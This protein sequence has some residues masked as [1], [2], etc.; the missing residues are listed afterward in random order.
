[1]MGSRS[2]SRASGM[3]MGTDTFQIS[4]ASPPRR[5]LFKISGEMLA[6]SDG[7]GI[8]S[9][10]LRDLAED[11]RGA[12]A[13]KCEMAL[14][15]GAGNIVRGAQLATEGVNRATADYMGMLGTVINALALADILRL[16][17]VPARVMTA[18]RMAPAAEPYERAAA[19]DSIERG[20]VVIFAAGTGNPYF[21]TDTAAALRAVEIGADLLAKGTK[22]DG[23]Y[24]KDPALHADALL[25]RRV[26][27]DQ[28]LKDRLGVMD[29]AAVAMCRD[30]SLPV[31]VFRL[32]FM[33]S[34]QR[35]AAGNTDGTLME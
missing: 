28:V 6:A 24:D 22:V 32:D 11:I 25:H 16:K 12:R 30:N 18:I 10:R 33:R 1:M 19:L 31:L 13:F 15:V 27:Y 29:A 17:G 34:L 2:R 8:D 20:E 4:N 23:V 9:D 5:V 14:V 7:R 3:P 21:T 26:S 35:V